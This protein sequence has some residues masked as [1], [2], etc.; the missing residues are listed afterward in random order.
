[1][2]N[3]IKIL[4]LFVLI[5]F[6]AK[7]QNILEGGSVHGNFEINAQYYNTDDKL[8]ITDSVLNG[9]VLG[10]NAFGNI[11]Y[12]NGNFSAGIRYEAYLPPLSGFDIRY[13]GHG[14]PYWFASYKTKDV[15]AESIAIAKDIFL[16]IKGMCD[17]VHFMPI[18]ANHLVA[19]ILDRVENK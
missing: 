12:T 3:S 19:K 1:M 13:E 9:K 6:M 10:T 2:K 5:P 7:S 4:L 11:I 15:E 14:I 16:G 18:R 8:G 17:G